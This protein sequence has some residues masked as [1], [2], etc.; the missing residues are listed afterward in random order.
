MELIGDVL[1]GLDDARV[2]EE[3]ELAGKRLQTF[4][5]TFGENDPR[6]QALLSTYRQILVGGDTKSYI[7][8][9]IY[10]RWALLN[11]G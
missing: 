1:L 2:D 8:G 10:L 6:T 9:G 5:D 11:P 7:I 4:Q 3:I